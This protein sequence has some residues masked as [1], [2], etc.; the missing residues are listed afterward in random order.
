MLVPSPN[1]N[2][3]PEP[4]LLHTDRRACRE[5]LSTGSRTFLAASWFLPR[6]RRDAATALYAFCREADD[7]VDEG[8]GDAEALRVVQERLDQVYC[9]RPQPFPADRAFACVVH[10]YH[11]PQAL[12]AALIEG[13]AWDA[14]GRRYETIEEL[15]EYAVRVAGTV[16]VMMALLMDV[17]SPSALARACDL[18]VAMQLTNIA[19]D[20]GEDARNGRLYLPRQWLREAGIDPEGFLARPRFTPALGGVI[21]R[22]LHRADDF[23][24]RAMPGFHAL[25]KRVRPGLC[26]A[27]LL[28][29]E[30]GRELERRGCD[31]V[32]Q[33]A[34]V[35]AQRKLR[36][37]SSVGT[38]L[39]RAPRD[40]S[41]PAL[42][43]GRF[44][45]DAVEQTPA[46]E[47]P[48]GRFEGQ[49]AWVLDLFERLERH[50]AERL[51]RMDAA[52]SGRQMSG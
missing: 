22:L 14:E 40:D 36:V 15:Y 20:V 32:H 39:A 37:L 31:S 24:E 38:T 48:P 49:V 30:I 16:G 3:A 4:Y 2:L 18:G 51:E 45:I 21:Q 5:L 10:Y 41:A 26:A 29:A 8:P 25:P 43:E 13:F 27:R 44:L 34:V 19:R 28:Y 50:D 42:P 23:Y 35:S 6:E 52:R 11:L 9:G 47:G 7:V 12:P 46:P 1:P 33:R 17:R